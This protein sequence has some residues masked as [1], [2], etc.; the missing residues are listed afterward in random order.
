MVLIVSKKMSNKIYFGYCS[1]QGM[2]GSVLVSNGDPIHIS[3][4]VQGCQDLRYIRIKAF[5]DNQAWRKQPSSDKAKIDFNLHTF[6]D[7][8]RPLFFR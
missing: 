6:I 2:L 1:K 5:A 4:G 8:C 7:H 3:Q